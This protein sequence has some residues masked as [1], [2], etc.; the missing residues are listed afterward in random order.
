MLIFTVQ[1]IT[2]MKK[3]IKEFNKLDVMDKTAVSFTGM[4]LSG[5][6]YAL[7]VLLTVTNTI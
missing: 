3:L 4:V 7:I 6:C 5:L 1:S 2:N